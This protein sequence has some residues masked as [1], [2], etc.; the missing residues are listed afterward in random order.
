MRILD[1]K[2]SREMRRLF[3]QI[4]TIALV[5]AGGVTCF[6][7][8]RGTYLSL[9]AARAE[10]YDRYRFAHVFAHAERVPES[11]AQKLETLPSV[12]RVET[13][14]AEEVMLPIAG[15]A[16]PA[17]GRLLSLP[18]GGE[19]RINALHLR[20]GRFPE[21]DKDE[22]VVL[23]S[24]AEA[25]GLKPGAQLPV[26][27][28]GKLRA[29]RV[30]GVALSPEFVFAIRPGSLA[31]DPKR[32]AVLWANRSLLAA[33]FQLEGAFNDVSLRLQAGAGD[34]AV[35]ADVDRIL[36]RYGGV[37]SVNRD[38]QISHRVLRQELSQL[39]SLAGM[40]PIVFLCVAAFLMNLVLGRLI[41]L[42][43]PEIA[44]LKAVGYT[45]REI[46]R[47]YLGLVVVVLA[48]GALLGLLGGYY[49]GRTVLALY[50]GSFRFPDLDFRLSPELV[51]AAFGA[52]GLAAVV[53]ALGAVRGAVKLPPAEAMQPPPPARYARGMLERLRLTTFVGPNGMMVLREVARRPLRT[54]FSSLGIAGAVALLILGRFGW[55][56]LTDY[57]ESTFRREQR[58]DLSVTF[59]RPVAPRVVNQLAR[60]PG[61]DS[62]EGMRVVPI[63]IRHEHRMRDSL[64][65]GIPEKAQLRRLV[66]RGGGHEVSLP[67]DG[68]LLTQT[69][70]DVLG[71]R[72]GDRPIIE[73]REGER[74]SVRPV[75]AGFI[76]ESV[77]MQ[78][79]ARAELV[80]TLEGDHGAVSTVLL[81]VDRERVGHVQAELRRSPH[82]IDVS[83]VKADMQRLF[84]MNASIMSVWTAISIALAS[85]VVFGVVYNNA[86][87]SLA[88]RSRDLASLRVLGFSRREISSI[89]LSE[90][91]IEVLLALPAGLWLGRY[92]S[93]KF[94]ETAD[95]ETFRW[96]VVVSPRTYLL[97]VVV[98]LLAAAA[99]ALWVRRSL[100]RLDL[101]SVLKA[102]E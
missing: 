12:A 45:N 52:S 53:G 67:A 60:L 71:I 46:T 68:L 20:L 49:L 32:Y 26:V 2:L 62:A 30:V 58:Q 27:I 66:T 24:F 98:T 13:R 23:E 94:M 89:L 41:R 74:R 35:R 34:A 37:G 4:V 90:L 17:Y 44:T 38:G 48:P 102:R 9:E 42:Q 15:M 81:K 25:H 101:V 59:A 8:L 47:H 87:I 76:D 82:V 10:Y 57:F 86:R 72:I 92:W 3:G 40:I 7:S 19:P 29:L 73:L 80:A 56:S 93:Q 33:A 18:E 88:A 31:D 83:D 22:A 61:V 63:R 78:L 55:D 91:A 97:A 1:R 43:R 75:V 79:Y 16:R 28:N 95:Q 39:E 50:A 84:D 21:P 5:L 36:A 51:G 77:G 99:S 96:Q 11:V 54:L 64:L 6:I 100:D 69:F 85:S 14:I 65:L 70:A